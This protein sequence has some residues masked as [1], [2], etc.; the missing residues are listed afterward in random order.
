[1]AIDVDISFCLAEPVTAVELRGFLAA[2]EEHADPVAYEVIV[3]GLDCSPQSPEGRSLQADFPQLTIYEN[4]PPTPGRRLNHAMGLAVGRYLA[5]WSPRIYPLAGCLFNLVQFMDENPESGLAAPRLL[6]S[7]SHL[8]PSRRRVPGLAVILLLHTLLGGSGLGGP[9]LKRHYHAGEPPVF[10]QAAAGFLSARALLLRRE[11]LE[12]IGPFDEGFKI[13]YFDADYCRRAAKA[14]WHCHY[15]AGAPARDLA[16]ECFYLDFIRRTSPPG[17]L[18]DATR[19]L[20]K[21]WLQIN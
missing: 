12:E 3:A 14:G 4:P 6:D 15:L 2:V 16:P 13:F 10:Q 1:M 9:L 8:L 5:P 20:L 19:V 11:T 21:K 7:D 17:H 18:A